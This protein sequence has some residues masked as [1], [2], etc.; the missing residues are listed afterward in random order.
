MSLKIKQY[1]VLLAGTV[2]SSTLFAQAGSSLSV[3]G[4]ADVGVRYT[5]NTD[6]ADDSSTK[7]ANGSRTATRLGFRGSEALST[8]LQAIFTME[9]GID[10]TTGA[11]GDGTRHFNRLTFVGLKS[12]TLGQ[13]TIGR[14]YGMIHEFLG[15]NGIDPL[16][17][18][19]H[20]EWSYYVGSQYTPRYDSSIRYTHK[21]GGFVVSAM[22]VIDTSKS[23]TSYPLGATLV[24]KGTNWQFGGAYMQEKPSIETSDAKR[25]SYSVGG[26]YQFDAF[27]LHGFYLE[28]KNNVTD[29]KDKTYAAGF[30]YDLSPSVKLLGEVLHTKSDLA[31]V[32]G[33][34]TAGILTA[35]YYLSK[36]TQPY[37]GVDY[38]KFSDAL[39]PASGEDS[40]VGLAI[41]LRH[42]F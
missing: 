21:I 28:H 24:Y 12:N 6:A 11:A 5:S 25:K 7:L 3:Y 4:I 2:L 16:D 40:R 31:N 34:R 42:R 38:T 10:P 27:K 8:D 22:G 13:L 37:V 18:A 41:G 20:P 29:R 23:K 35:E 32:D 26:T 19:N 15:F 17:V 39:I 30:G 1:P 14:Q 9:M 36:R 33:K